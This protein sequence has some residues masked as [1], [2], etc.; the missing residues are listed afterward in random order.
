[1]NNMAEYN[2]VQI[3]LRIDSKENWTTNNTVLANGEV[4]IVVDGSSIDLKAG[5][6]GASF[7]SL[8]YLVG[9]NA[10]ITNLGSRIDT[11]NDR[12][13]TLQGNINLLGQ[14]VATDRGNFNLELVNNYTTSRKMLDEHIPG[15]GIEKRREIGS[16]AEW[17]ASGVYPRHRLTDAVSWDSIFIILKSLKEA[18]LLPI[19][20]ENAVTFGEK[21]KQHIGELSNIRETE[22]RDAL[23]LYRNGILG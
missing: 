5:N 16:W 17:T 2:N 11:S 13:N 22:G 6:N 8:P 12:I 1:M 21:L 19:T 3:R 7:T 4:G 15:T 18:G 20:D 23:D 10:A 14:N 9:D